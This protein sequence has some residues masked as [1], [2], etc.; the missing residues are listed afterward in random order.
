MPTVRLGNAVTME[1]RQLRIT[2]PIA[3]IVRLLERLA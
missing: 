1:R 2:R 3:R